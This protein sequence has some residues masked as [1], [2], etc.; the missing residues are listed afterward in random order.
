MP[1][2][3]RMLMAFHS[4]SMGVASFLQTVNNECHAIGSR[5]GRQNGIEKDDI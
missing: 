2:I 4:V 5:H 1:P 3:R